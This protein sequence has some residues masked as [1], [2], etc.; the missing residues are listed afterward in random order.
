MELNAVDLMA[1]M[2]FSQLAIAAYLLYSFIDQERA[3]RR[4]TNAMLAHVERLFAELEKRLATGS[5]RTAEEL[6]G[7]IARGSPPP[8]AEA[9]NPRPRAKTPVTRTRTVASP[10]RRSH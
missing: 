7:I 5:F 1:F 10:S 6:E 2:L 9:T 4:R 3:S 8:A